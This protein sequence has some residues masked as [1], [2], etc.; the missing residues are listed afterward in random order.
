MEDPT[1]ANGLALHIG[2]NTVDPRHYNGRDGALVACEADARDMQAL[3]MARGFDS[4]LLLA[5][6]GTQ[7]NV[8]AAIR[9][10]AGQLASGDIF[11]LTYS[12]HGGQV[13]DRHGREGE[14]DALDELGQK[15]G[16]ATSGPFLARAARLVTSAPGS[17]SAR[18]FP[19][20]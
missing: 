6:E 15:V 14:P 11:L 16:Y 13:P 3:A 19:R 12:G 8:T 17:Y 18:I 20:V 10:A 2:L 1:I 5:R 7:R 9:D 4:R